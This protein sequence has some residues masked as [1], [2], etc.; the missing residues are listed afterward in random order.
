VPRRA[1]LLL[2]VVSSLAAAGCGR[3]RSRCE[4]VCRRAAECTRELTEQVVDLSECI[5]ECTKLDRESALQRAVGAHVKCVDDAPT[6][7]Q[8]LEC[9]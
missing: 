2:L 5:D 3:P 6:C 1:L 8:V 9:P 7:E 4:R